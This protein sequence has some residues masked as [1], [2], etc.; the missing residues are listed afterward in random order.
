MVDDRLVAKAAA[1]RA[2]N[3]DGGLVLPNAWDAVSARI[4]EVAGFPAVGST[5]AGVAYARGYGDAERIGREAMVRE[6]E[7]MARVVDIPVTAD[8]EAGYGPAHA[9]VAATVDGVIAAG[10]VG[11]NLEDRVHGGSQRG[12]FPVDEAAARV[13]AARAAAERQGVPLVINARTDTFLLGLGVDLAERVA[14]TIERGRAYLAAGA[15]LVFVPGA[16]ELGTVREIVAGIGGPVSLMVVPGLAPAA[17]VFAAGV[18]RISMGPA[19]QLAT[20]GTLRQVANEVRATGDW[21]ALA[22][23]GFG[24][25]DAEAL[26]A[27]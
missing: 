25:G 19:A 4:L 9:D 6:I 7:I 2:L 24:F 26:F 23:H 16:A 5:S 15:D 3:L 18:N 12:V 27:R 1:F 14:L 11:I 21:A 20:L 8:I 10:A 13:A 17:E 22:G